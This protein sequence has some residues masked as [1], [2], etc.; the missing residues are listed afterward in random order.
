MV[1]QRRHGGPRVRTEDAADGDD[2]RL[3]RQPRHVALVDGVRE[4]VAVQATTREP[5]P[6]SGLTA[7]TVYA[8]R[9]RPTLETAAT[10]RCVRGGSSW[11]MVV[12]LKIHYVVIFLQKI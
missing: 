2:V 1:A 11:F 4:M 7:C 10:T 6:P 9:G 5:P 8:R 3:G 12:Q